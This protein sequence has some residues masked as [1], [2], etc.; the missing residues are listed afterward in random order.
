MASE[1]LVPLVD[2][3][4]GTNND[5]QEIFRWFVVCRGLGRRFDGSRSRPAALLTKKARA[6]AVALEKKLSERTTWD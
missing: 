6:L 5:R 3:V 1:G 4:G 2:D